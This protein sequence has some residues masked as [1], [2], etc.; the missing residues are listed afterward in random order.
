[1]IG[2]I[3]AMNCEAEKLREM[4]SDSRSEKLGASVYTRGRL[5]KTEVV[6][7]VCGIGKVF[8]GACA[9]TMIVDFG[10]THIF[11]IGA[12]G[13]LS[14]KVGIG[15]IITASATVQYD[16]DTSALGDPVGLISGLDVV[17]MECDKSFGDSFAQFAAKQGKTLKTGIIAT[18]DKFIKRS[19]DKK[20]LAEHFGASAGEMEGA[21]VGQICCANGVPYNV[22]RVITDNASEEAGDE[23]SFNLEECAVYLAQL[24]AQYLQSK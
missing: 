21:A 20:L 5:G 1:M 13:S 7:S 22:I 3:T 14:E 15:D 6:V 24:F 23:Y 11:N 8:A 4:L 18:G 17:E 2:I 12:A 19:E 9:Q 16:M 10:C